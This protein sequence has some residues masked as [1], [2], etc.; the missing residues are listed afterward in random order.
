MQ[1]YNI[2][3]V[4]IIAYDSHLYFASNYFLRRLSCFHFSRLLGYFL[5]IYFPK[6]LYFQLLYYTEHIATAVH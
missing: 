2:Y 5:R 1:I 6:N 4:L 3:N